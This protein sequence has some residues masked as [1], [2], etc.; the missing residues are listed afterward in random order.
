M[1]GRRRSRSTRI[2][3]FPACAS[4]I[5]RLAAVVDLPSPERA[6]ENAVS[7]GSRLHLDGAPRRLNECGVPRLEGCHRRQL[8][9]L[10]DQVL[11]E[12]GARVAGELE[13]PQP[14]PDVPAS[15]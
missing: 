11:V 2:T 15:A 9:L 4:A 12:C 5:A 14:R 13:L 1:N 6:P 7:D 3:L 8:L 10:F